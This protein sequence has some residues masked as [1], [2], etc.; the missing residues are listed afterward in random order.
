VNVIF[1]ADLLCFDF[2]CCS[3]LNGGAALL[4]SAFQRNKDGL[5]KERKKK[6]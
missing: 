1:I 2:Q 6:K 5:K 3:R 4:C